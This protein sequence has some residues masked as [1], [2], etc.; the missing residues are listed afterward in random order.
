VLDLL[1][2]YGTLR[3]G[4]ENPYARLLHAEADLAGPATVPGSIYRVKHYPAYKAD[5]VG[6]VHGEV[7]R[8]RN[9]EMTLRVL[10]EYEGDEFERVIVSGY[11]LYRYVPEP[12]QASRISSGDF[13]AR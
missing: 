1:F 7:Y 8:L 6:E 4:H 13:P 2:V 10:D 11:W 3:S 9:P 5:P 12:A